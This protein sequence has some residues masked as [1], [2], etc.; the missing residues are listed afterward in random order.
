MIRMH[1]VHFC[2]CCNNIIEDDY[3]EKVI[4]F[5]EFPQLETFLFCSEECRQE[6]IEEYFEEGYVYPSGKIERE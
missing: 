5:L 1:T 2:D 4:Y 3:E 6:F